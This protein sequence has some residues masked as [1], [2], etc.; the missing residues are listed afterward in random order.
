MRKQL[1]LILISFSALNSV[2]NSQ[3]KSYRHNRQH[4][5]NQG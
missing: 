4:S 2:S 1:L 5:S 3:S